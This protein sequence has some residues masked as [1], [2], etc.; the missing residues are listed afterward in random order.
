MEAEALLEEEETLEAEEALEV[1]EALEAE[2]ALLALEEELGL[3]L[4]VAVDVSVHFA[5]RVVFCVILF[6][7]KFHKVLNCVSLN[8]PTKI[9]FVF[10]GGGEG[11]EARLL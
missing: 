2:D 6:W 8:Q 9:K 11:T 1:E 3:L 4:E 10:V 7:E 5:Y